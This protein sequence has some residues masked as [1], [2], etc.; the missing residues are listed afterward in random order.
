MADIHIRDVSDELYRAL[1]VRA[2]EQRCTL[3]ALVVPALE[4]LVSTKTK[5]EQR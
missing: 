4:A 2:V 3:K 5:G 1:K